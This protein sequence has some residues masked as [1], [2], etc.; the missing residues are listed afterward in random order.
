MLTKIDTNTIPADGGVGSQAGASASQSIN[1]PL[2]HALACSHSGSEVAVALGNGLVPVFTCLAEG[3]YAMWVSRFALTQSLLAA[4][5]K[6][7]RRT[8]LAQ[9]RSAV[10]AVHFPVFG[11][12]SFLA[13]G[14]ND[15]QVVLWSNMKKPVPVRAHALDHKR[16]VNWLASAGTLRSSL[17]VADT[18]PFL[19]EYVVRS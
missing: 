13:T 1:P 6:L 2:A 12:D 4:P 18:S 9:H 17:F 15:S 14:G 8:T 5:G 16:K 19:T 11:S 10:C 7:T 3:I